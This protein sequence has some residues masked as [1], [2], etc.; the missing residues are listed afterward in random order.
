MI[1]N[2]ATLQDAIAA[3]LK[4]ADLTSQIPTFIQFAEARF[5]RELRVAQMLVPVTGTV[6]ALGQID[7][8]SDCRKV[9]SVRVAIGSSYMELP[10]LPPSYLQDT[11]PATA[12]ASGYVH[13]G[14]D[15]L[16]L[17][18]G[19][20]TPAYAVNYWQKVPSLSA[21]AATNWLLER[22]PSLYLYAAL[23]ESAPYL[24]DD[25]RILV[26]AGQYKSV[27][28]AMHAEDDDIR[29]GNSPAMRPAM[30]RAP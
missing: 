1:T 17:I 26:W 12:L 28:D 18:G 30:R 22:E 2:Y 16:Q 23:I 25:E 6:S 11:T 29:Y 8:P 3:W 7:L 10:P 4:R 24:Q 20:G 13:I 14:D 9:Q 15:T 19:N 27:L 21:T 5:N